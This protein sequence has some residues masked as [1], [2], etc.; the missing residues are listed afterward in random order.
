MNLSADIIYTLLSMDTYN[1]GYN[2]GIKFGDS[3]DERSLDTSRA[4]P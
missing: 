1:R 4:R 3:S 2:P